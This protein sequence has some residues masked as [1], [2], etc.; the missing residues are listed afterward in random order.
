MLN[1]VHSDLE[2]DIDNLK[3]NSNTEFVLEESS[4]NELNCDDKSLTFLLP[5]ANYHV[6]EDPAIEKFRRR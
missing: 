3:S 2:D 5:G 1:K 4:E 6:V